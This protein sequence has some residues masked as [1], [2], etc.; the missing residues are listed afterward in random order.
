MNQEVMEYMLLI[1]LLSSLLLIYC[2]YVINDESKKMKYYKKTI[3]YE[4]NWD[5]YSDLVS[6]QKKI[7]RK[8]KIQLIG[9][10][11]LVFLKEGL[12]WKQ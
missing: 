2:F 12:K 5:K 1:I 3:S 7:I 4:T 11:I 9:L 6:E 8:K 10:N